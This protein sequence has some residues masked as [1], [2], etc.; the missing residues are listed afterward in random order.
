MS[1]RIC[2]ASLVAIVLIGASGCS[3]HRKVSSAPPNASPVVASTP[4]ATPSVP[5]NPVAADVAFE[6]KVRPILATSCAPCHNPGG[7]MYE[8]MPF[9][10]ATTVR[11]HADGIRKR[12]KGDNLQAL[13]AWLA[14][15]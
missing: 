9:D 14:G 7:K 12:L 11:S 13:E 3:P 4:M 8:R 5:A 10:D 1:P 6:A 15:S 2:A